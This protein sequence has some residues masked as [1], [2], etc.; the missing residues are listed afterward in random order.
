MSIKDCIILALMASFDLYWPHDGFVGHGKPSSLV[1]TLS[2]RPSLLWCGLLEGEW[3]SPR[4]WP[5]RTIAGSQ[6]II[7]RAE[8]RFRL[9]RDFA[10]GCHI[11]DPWGYVYDVLVRFFPCRV[12][13]NSNR[14]DTLTYE[15]PHDHCSHPV[16]CLVV[17]MAW[18]RGWWLWLCL[19]YWLQYLL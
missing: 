13:T 4:W 11:W 15:W 12:Y 3:G 17:L 9:S 5:G 6:D 19:S 18:I 16:V 10:D 7:P 1:T 14:C 2:N 8:T